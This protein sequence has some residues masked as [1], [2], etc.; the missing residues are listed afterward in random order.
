MCRGPSCK[1]TCSSYIYLDDGLLQVDGA[2]RRTRCPCEKY[3]AGC[4]PVETLSSEINEQ[5]V[6]REKG[7]I[8]GVNASLSTNIGDK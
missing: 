1:Y 6:E 5:M 2:R 7:E 4:K 3:K 8:K